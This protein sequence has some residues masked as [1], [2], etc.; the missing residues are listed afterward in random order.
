MKK[1]VKIGIIVVILLISSISIYY[2]NNLPLEVEVELV[3]KTTLVSDFKETGK[4]VADEKFSIPAPYDGRVN[5]II[6]LGEEVEKGDLIAVFDH[7]E[8]TYG[9]RQINGQLSSLNGQRDM[10]SPQIY[11]AQV[12]ALEIAIDM[13]KTGIERLEDDLE[14]YRSLYEAGAVA[15][16][17]VDSMEKALEDGKKSLELREK[18]LDLVYETNVERKGTE[19]FYQGQRSALIAQRDSLNSKISRSKVYAPGPG[20]VTGVY[21]TEGVFASSTMPIL[22]ISNN[23]RL[24]ARTNTLVR[25]GASLKLGDKVKVVQK[26]RNEDIVHEGI[27]SRISPLAKTTIS[28][29]GLSEQRVEVDIEFEGARDLFIGYD[30]DI[31][32]ETKRL[33]DVIVLSRLSIFR[34]NGRYFVWKVEEDI[35]KKQE[36]KIGYESDFEVEILEG[37]NEGDIIIMDPNNTALVEGGRVTY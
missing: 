5:M 11:Q 16:I 21:V 22:D 35:I 1:S 20:I 2:Y 26:L 17:E 15:K 10:S 37:I 23:E 7:S 13:A 19:G 25:D 18:E 6:K 33:E 12:E 36:V 29:L 34:E 30:L 8:L 31:I 9:V 14:T 27:I 3:E 4:I 28:P 24:V 32:I